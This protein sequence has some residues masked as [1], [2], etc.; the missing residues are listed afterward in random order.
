MLKVS[1][2]RNRNK[3]ITN[4]DLESKGIV[5]LVKD[6]VQLCCGDIEIYKTWTD[7]DKNFCFKRLYE[8]ESRYVPFELLERTVGHI[9]S[10]KEYVV[11]IRVLGD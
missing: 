4:K 5:M 10:Y 7:S 6:L 9:A 1:V 3:S 11:S 8:G 2:V